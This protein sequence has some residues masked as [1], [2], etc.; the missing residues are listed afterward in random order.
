MITKLITNV[1]A[2][3]GDPNAAISAM[4]MNSLNEKNF[5]KAAIKIEM[6]SDINDR[7]VIK[8]GN[9]EYDTT[10]EISPRVYTNRIKLYKHYAEKVLA[11]ESHELAVV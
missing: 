11:S 9:T 2:I 3:R 5:K 1:A 7:G 8:A 4:N 6:P 10:D